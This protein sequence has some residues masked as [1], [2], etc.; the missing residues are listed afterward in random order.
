VPDPDAHS[1]PVSLVIAT[2]DRPQSLVTCLAA[3]VEGDR[4]PAEIVIVDQGA[5]SALQIVE[6]RIGSPGLLRY[7]QI[8]DGGVSRARNAGVGASTS[9]LIAFTDDDCVPAPAWL[10]ELVRACSGSTAGATGRVL[11]LP[12][13]RANLVAVSSRTSEEHRLHGAGSASPPW[14]VGTGGNLLLRREVLEA[15][16]G[17]DERFGPGA[18]FKAAEDIELLERVLSAGY[19]V[20]YTPDAIVYHE[21]KTRRER[22][23]TRAPYG[24]G[25]GA[26]LATR[27]GRGGQLSRLLRP[28][29]RMQAR[30]LRLGVTSRSP[31]QLLEPLVVMVGVVSG[32]AAYLSPHQKRRDATKDR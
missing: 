20:A 7:L 17:F 15:V 19:T 26:F 12:S 24:Y 6:A 29:A 25:M 21:M 27:A 5:E 11:P 8:A 3:V 4:K 1:L 9:A 30:A 23:A 28:Y 16:G 22:L 32:F 10:C 31:R 14:E 18:P 2:K 13:V